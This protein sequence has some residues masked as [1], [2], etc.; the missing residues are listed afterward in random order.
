MVNKIYDKLSERITLGTRLK[1]LLGEFYF[2]PLL[3]SIA[4]TVSNHFTTYFEIVDAT[5][6]SLGR[7]IETGVK[8]K[9]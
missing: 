9:V 7:G 6:G 4:Y 1:R 3:V 2:R 8:R 5:T